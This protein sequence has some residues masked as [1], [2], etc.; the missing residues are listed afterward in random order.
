MQFEFDEAKRLSN[1]AKHDLDF[2]DADILFAGP[3]LIGPARAVG[4]EDR[5][6]AVGMIEDVHVTVIF[7]RRGTVIRLISMRRAR[8]DERKR[9][10]ALHGL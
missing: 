3:M 1:I 2:L 6:M 8:D 4:G 10:Q 7:T 9:H 5:W